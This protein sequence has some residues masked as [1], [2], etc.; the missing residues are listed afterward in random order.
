MRR[1]TRNLE[2]K[3][4]KG[5]KKKRGEANQDQGWE[6]EIGETGEVE[7]E[8]RMNVEFKR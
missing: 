1:L 6:I 7:N 5:R 2:G 8:I 3:G 4:R